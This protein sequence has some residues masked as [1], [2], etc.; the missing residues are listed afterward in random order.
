MSNF[1]LGLTRKKEG[2]CGVENHENGLM[3]Y[4]DTF[5]IMI[6]SSNGQKILDN[7]L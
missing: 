6:F 2:V 7:Y 1:H 5:L 4:D 3:F